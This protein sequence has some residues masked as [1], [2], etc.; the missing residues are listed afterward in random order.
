MVSLNMTSACTRGYMLAA[1][2]IVLVMLGLVD[3]CPNEC[4]AKGY[5]NPQRPDECICYDGFTG[6]DCSLRVCPA[7]AAWVDYATSKNA[8]H[9]NFT[10]C[11]GFGYCDRETG[12]CD[13][14]PGFSGEACQ[15]SLCPLGTHP[16]SS[17]VS[18]CSGRGRCMSIREAG[19]QIDYKVRN[20]S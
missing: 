3:A 18:M 8:A 7:G 15:R 4:S 12:I 5:C 6:V 1:A 9:K 10:E 20:R 14:R 17:A 11:S 13:C 16:Q 19:D 2:A